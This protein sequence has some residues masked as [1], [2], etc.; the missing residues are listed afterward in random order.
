MIDNHT[1]NDTQP[2]TLKYVHRIRIRMNIEQAPSQHMIA[3]MRPFF[4]AP[5]SIFMFV[6]ISPNANVSLNSFQGPKLQQ[7]NSFSLFIYFFCPLLYVIYFF[8]SV[9]FFRQTNVHVFHRLLRWK[10]HTR[11]LLIF[12]Q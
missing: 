2:F 4:S 12:I 10:F 7:R 5:F 6:W 11:I 9:I 8:A 1:G 3:F